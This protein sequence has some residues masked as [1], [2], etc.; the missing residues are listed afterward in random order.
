[1]VEVTLH[2]EYAHETY[3]KAAAIA[4]AIDAKIRMA[5]EAREKEARDKSYACLREAL[6]KIGL[7]APKAYQ[8]TLRSGMVEF[9]WRN[10][11]DQ[12][13][14]NMS[15]PVPEGYENDDRFCDTVSI[16]VE[17]RPLRVYQEAMTPEQYGA[18]KRAYFMDLILQRR[19]AA[20]ERNQEQLKRIQANTDSPNTATIPPAQQAA[21][22]LAE[23]LEE[24]FYQYSVFTGAFE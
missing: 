13:S 15:V 20:M 16:A 7:V 23:A 18:Y 22:K 3:N 12:L 24:F 1:M 2:T 19:N 10:W 9:T 17:D 5:E 11:G 6:A 14:F 21:R 8:D 4:E